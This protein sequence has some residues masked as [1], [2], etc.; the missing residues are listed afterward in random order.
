MREN[1]SGGK[2]ERGNLNYCMEHPDAH[3]HA[4]LPGLLEHHGRSH[5][6]SVNAKSA[7]II[8]YMRLL[9]PSIYRR[10]NRKIPYFESSASLMLL[11]V[12]EVFLIV[13]NVKGFLQV[14]FTK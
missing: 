1:A 9:I 8:I 14:C 7:P 2:N 5:I 12:G 3:P 13:R 4:R 6:H 11:C 10:I